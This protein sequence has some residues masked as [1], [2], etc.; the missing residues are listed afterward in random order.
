MNTAEFEQHVEKCIANR[1]YVS[2]EKAEQMFQEAIQHFHENP[3][4]LTLVS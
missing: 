3:A 1:G 4:S 2:P